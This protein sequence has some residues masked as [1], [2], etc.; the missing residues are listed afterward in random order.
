M[1]DGHTQATPPALPALPVA[2]DITTIDACPKGRFRTALASRVR[3]PFEVRE[4][5]SATLRITIAKAAKGELEA[6]ASFKGR[7][8]IASRSVRGSCD[9]ITSALALV[10]ATWFEAEP[11]LE[12]VPAAVPA[13]VDDEPAVAPAATTEP[14]PSIPPVVPPPAVAPRPAAAP[15]RRPAP[16]SDA[17]AAGPRKRF[18]LGAHGLATF[19]LVGNA[20]G[21]A[22]VALAFETDRFELR[23]GLRGALSAET[24]PSGQAH[25]VWV[26]APIDGC[27]HALTGRVLRLAGCLRVEP[28]Y[29]RVSFANIQDGEPWLSTA[30]AARLGWS[31]GPIRLELEGAL[32]LPITG[33]RIT[34][35]ET[36]F[37]PFRALA[38]GLAAGVMIPFW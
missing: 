4:E 3:R 35:T 37:D 31:V 33:Y 10:A 14:P 17:G 2:I 9:E 28:G 27:L 11:A 1:H 18:S 30:A 23:G 25:H 22:G 7:S 21:G 12:P 6:R 15:P 13:S 24:L 26:T 8:G 29:F 20:A 16:P 32:T 19:G 34:R 38:P 36:T 5:A